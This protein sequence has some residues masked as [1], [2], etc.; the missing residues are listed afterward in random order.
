MGGRIDMAFKEIESNFGPSWPGKEPEAGT[1]ATGKLTA[2]T[3]SDFDKNNYTLE[4]AAVDG[5]PVE[6]GKLTVWG[7]SVLCGKLNQ[8]NIGVK[9]RV[10]Y[11]GTEP[12]KVRGQNPTKMFKVEADA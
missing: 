11:L 10:T 2:K 4:D 1:C 5:Q 8:V 3:P 6:G 9:V 7:S 12:P